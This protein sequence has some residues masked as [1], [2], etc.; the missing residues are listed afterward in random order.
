MS[1]PVSARAKLCCRG[2]EQRDECSTGKGRLWRGPFPTRRPARIPLKPD[3]PSSDRM[4]HTKSASRVTNSVTT[5]AATDG[6]LWRG[7]F[8]ISPA[9]L[10]PAPPAPPAPP[11][12]PPCAQEAVVTR[13]VSSVSITS[14]SEFSPPSN[15]DARKPFRA[16]RA[17][18]TGLP[19]RD[20]E[21][22]TLARY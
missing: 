3:I 6:R 7:P 17:P 8:P 9:A 1:V 21:S 10:P 2:G 14:S 15:V 20:W 12:P 19:P 16:S 13:V 5:T 4:G 11:P 22:S 18:G